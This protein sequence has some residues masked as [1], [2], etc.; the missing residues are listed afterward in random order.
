MSV[1]TLDAIRD[2]WDKDTGKGRDAAKARELADAYV[3]AHPDQF[4]ELATMSLEQCVQA[5]DVF[6]AAGM[7]DSQWRAEAWLLHHFEPQTIGGPVDAKVRI[8]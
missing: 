2:A 3:A 5:V 7:A 4:T 6:R 8:V 1:P